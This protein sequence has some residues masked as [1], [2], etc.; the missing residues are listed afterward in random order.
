M[1]KI[2]ITS[3]DSL[4]IINKISDYALKAKL[5]PCVQVLSGADS[6]YIWKGRIESHKEYLLFI[7]C[8]NSN[9]KKIANYIESNHNYETPEIIETDFEILN[10]EYKKWFDKSSI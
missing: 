8:K 9:S 3:T 2:I 10:E 5:S 1:Y 7:K 6:R 4:E